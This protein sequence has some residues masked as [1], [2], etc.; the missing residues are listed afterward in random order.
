[1]MALANQAKKKVGNFHRSPN[2]SQIQS[3]TQ[4]GLAMMVAKARLGTNIATAGASANHTVEEKNPSFTSRTSEDY[5][6]LI[7]GPNS[8]MPCIII[9]KSFYLKF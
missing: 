5:I 4:N 3:T 8:D 6:H 2:A 1:M 7:K 9:I